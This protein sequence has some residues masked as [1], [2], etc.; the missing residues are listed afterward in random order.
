[1]NAKTFSNALGKVNDKYVSEAIEYKGHTAS[2]HFNRRWA[3]ALVAA[4]LTLFLM[5][6][7]FAIT[8]YLDHAESPDIFEGIEHHKLTGDGD[9]QITDTI[10][11]G[12]LFVVPQAMTTNREEITVKNNSGVEVVVY[13]FSDWNLDEVIREM[14]LSSGETKSFTGLTSRFLYNIGIHTEETTQLDLTIS[15]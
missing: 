10:N 15:D 4:T 2:H 12:D 3:V 7:S 9:L 11:S 8:M 13:L 1:M 14:K 6:A 5:G